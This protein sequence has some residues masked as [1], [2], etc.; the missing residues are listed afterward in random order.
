MEWNII[1]LP[2]DQ[3]NWNKWSLIRDLF[4]NI[5]IQIYSYASRIHVQFSPS[6]SSSTAILALLGEETFQQT[7]TVDCLCFWVAV[8]HKTIFPIY[9]NF[10]AKMWIHFNCTD[11]RMCT[12]SLFRLGVA[13]LLGSSSPVY[14]SCLLGSY[15]VS[16]SILNVRVDYLYECM[17]RM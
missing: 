5:E 16:V 2:N 7:G 1:P 4:A 10:H 3:I 13:W 11:V 12:R 17:Y 6:S 14:M 15:N 9:W 8:L